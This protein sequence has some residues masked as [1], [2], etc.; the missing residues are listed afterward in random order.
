MEVVALV[1]SVLEELQRLHH[2]DHLVSITTV[3]T[4]ISL[5]HAQLDIIVHQGAT[6]LFHV[7]KEL[8]KA[9]QVK[10]LA[11]LVQL[12]DIVIKLLFSVHQS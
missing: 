7:Q 3:G 1:M 5:D 4:L 2:Q 6:T 12:E 10:V 8:T 9:Q 11:Q